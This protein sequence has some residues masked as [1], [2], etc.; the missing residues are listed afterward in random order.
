MANDGSDHHIVI[1]ADCHAGA[2]L[3]AYKPYVEARHHR[4]FDEWAASVE[5]GHKRLNEMMGGR[6]VMNVGVDGDPAVDGDR[7]WSTER[8]L[9]EQEAD[10]V[11][12]E[13][14]FPNTQPPFA[15]LPATM[16]EAPPLANDAELR[17]AGLRAHNRWL[18]D[19]VSEAPERRAGVA[20]V[21]LGDVEGS[22]REL[23]WARENGLRGGMLLPGA[24]PGSNF[25]PLY[26]PVY[27][28][29]WSACEDLD[30]TVNHH[31]GGG[32]PDFGAYFPSSMAMFML[33]VT[34]WGHRALW[35]LLF[36][37]VFERH[38]DL[39][40]VNTET[41]TKWIVDTL[42]ELDTFYDRMK[43]AKYG[44]E[45]IFGAMAVADLPLKPSEYWRRQCAIGASFLRPVECDLRDV[46][47]VEN[48]AWGNY[49]P[50]IES[51]HPFTRQHLRNTFGGVDIAETTQMITR[52]AARLY[53]FDLDALRPI[54][55][56]V[57]PTKD[58]VATPIDYRDIPE[59]ASKCPGL[60][61]HTQRQPASR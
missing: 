40:F 58:E 35:H 50:H 43:Y 54:A 51:S 36:S 32:T 15:P 12:G 53:H 55:D 3:W 2:D 25:E 45:S 31:S 61:P 17:F 14:I 29:L 60:A 19:F 1:S 44:S 10:G 4:A 22:V 18:A 27:E 26:S 28:P 30:L 16:F 8:R 37:G 33:E 49:D 48:I 57:C 52:N 34:W 56:R 21:F 41:G 20:Q 9:R 6:N 24:P 47:G 23:E 7:N 5:E 13:V 11:V 59:S 46:V 39:R 38:P 42:A